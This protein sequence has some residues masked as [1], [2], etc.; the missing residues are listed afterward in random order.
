MKTD[1]TNPIFPKIW[2]FFGRGKGKASNGLQF[3]LELASRNPMNGNPYL[4]IAEKYQ[5]QGQ[6]R[7]ALQE[8]LRAAELFCDTG[9]YNRGAAIYKSLLKEGY[10]VGL[11]RVKLSDAYG[12]KRLKDQTLTPY[13]KPYCSHKTTELEMRDK[14]LE[15]QDSRDK[16]NSYKFTLNEKCNLNKDLENRD[17]IGGSVSVHSPEEKISS[18]FDLAKI[19]EDNSSLEL[20]ESK[21]ITVEEIYG[22]GLV[23]KEFERN[24]EFRKTIS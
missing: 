6:E 14:G 5:K 7:K 4:K 2:R 10:E 17:R 1:K 16:S 8:Y 19:L 20:G 21:S 24:K 9:Q 13:P 23:F 18:L 3:S 12:K 15:I 11:V 22:P